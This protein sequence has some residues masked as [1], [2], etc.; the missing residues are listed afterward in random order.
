MI[1]E[2]L[3]GEFQISRGFPQNHRKPSAF[4]NQRKR[5]YLQGKIPE[6]AYDLIADKTGKIVSM[7]T[8]KELL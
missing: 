3:R 4:G 7:V 2:K 5:Q 6:K 1:A 8:E